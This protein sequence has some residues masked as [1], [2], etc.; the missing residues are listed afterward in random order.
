MIFIIFVI[1]SLPL[2]AQEDFGISDLESEFQGELFSQRFLGKRNLSPSSL[3]FL[4]A[5]KKI[6]GQIIT[7]ADIPKVDFKDLREITPLQT[8]GTGHLGTYKAFLGKKEV[9]IKYT[10][11]QKRSEERPVQ[12]AH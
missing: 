10:N 6:E 11:P 5:V 12:E 9:F 3:Q 8:G 2:F 7:F 4:E 1:F